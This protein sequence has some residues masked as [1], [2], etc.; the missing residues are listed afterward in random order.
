[1][2]TF[3]LLYVAGGL[4]MLGAMAEMY[5]GLERREH[6]AVVLAWFFLWPLIAFTFSLA[7]LRGPILAVW[8]Q[9]VARTHDIDKE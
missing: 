1:M 2:I 5:P 3:F 9:L 6:W 8:D 4:I 7:A